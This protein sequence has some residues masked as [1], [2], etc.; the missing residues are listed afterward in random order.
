MVKD[1][2]R[3]SRAAQTPWSRT[4]PG[5]A[6]YALASARALGLANELGH[7]VGLEANEV[8]K[9]WEVF[10]LPSLQHRQGHELRCEVVHPSNFG[11]A[12]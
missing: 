1:R 3:V 11:V 5:H 7:D 10:P 2:A 4:G 12:Q 6:A 9:Q 8:F